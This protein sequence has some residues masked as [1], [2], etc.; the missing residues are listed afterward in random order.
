MDISHKMCYGCGK[1]G[2]AMEKIKRIAIFI[3]TWVAATCVVLILG[4]IL[5]PTSPEGDKILGGG[6]TV[7]VFIIPVII[8]ILV[9]NK[10][11]IK[12]KLPEKKPTA[13]NLTDTAERTEE[14]IPPASA[15]KQQQ[16]ADKL[17]SDMRTTLSFC[18]DAPSLNLFV[19]WYDQAIA[20]LVKMVS[21]VKANFNFDPTYRLKT[22]RD[23]YQLHL[24]DAIV[25]IK[26][27]T[28]SEIDGKYKNSREFQEKALTEFCDDIGFVRSRFSP[29]TADVADKAISDIEKHLGINQ[30]P[31]ETSAHL[32]LWD[33][34][35]FM[36]GHRF[37][38]WCADVLRKIGFCNVE[39]T[40]GSGDQGVD[41]LAEKDGVKY[42]IQCKCYTSDLGN[43]PVQE[44]NT[45][46]AIY[47][48]QVGVVMTNRYFTQGAKDA[49]EAT[50]ILLWDRDVVQKMAKLAN[51]A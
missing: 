11:K 16:L 41:V 26:E 24:C 34:I 39:V 49:A 22:L 43:K 23:E 5:A 48:C 2:T 42:A 51:M 47:R 45:G 25:R 35:D 27:E 32:S 4:V 6:F 40:R 28:L 50:G 38:Y 8:A 7:A 31:E 10:D 20:D 21:L 18:E 44:V 37:E 3:G 12:A 36:D 1:G 29:G 13:L 19:H 15:A 33:N 30:H 9:V 14:F 17:V 46:K